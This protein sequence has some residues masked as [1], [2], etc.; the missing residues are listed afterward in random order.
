MLSPTAGQAGPEL[1]AAASRV[2]L[3]TESRVTLQSKRR[4]AA[5]VNGDGG[6][7][8]GEAVANIDDLE[9]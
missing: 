3:L 5:F 9:S 7:P 8:G 4:L 2:M 1:N 6:L